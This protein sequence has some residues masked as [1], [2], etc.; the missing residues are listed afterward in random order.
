MNTLG[1]STALYCLKSHFFRTAG[2]K[3]PFVTAHKE[4]VPWLITKCFVIKQGL[5][6][7]WSI[8]NLS[9]I[10][11]QECLWLITEVYDK[12]Q[13][14]PKLISKEVSGNSEVYHIVYAKTQWLMTENFLKQCN[15]HCSVQ[16]NTP[17][18]AWNR[19]D[20][21]LFIYFLPAET[22]LASD[23]NRTWEPFCW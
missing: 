19:S 14:H 3:V 10:V 17:L 6:S 11:M 22:E 7:L 5:F 4:K 21:L 12:S 9:V 1:K 18:A 23:Q 2:S 15:A 13:K 16:C 20:D 8:T